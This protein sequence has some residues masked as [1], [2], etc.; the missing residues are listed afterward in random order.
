MVARVEPVSMAWNSWWVWMVALV[1]P[2][3]VV[4]V[5]LEAMAATV[6]AMV[7]AVEVGG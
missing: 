5:A 6:E 7:V 4:E 1:V 3:G 2:T